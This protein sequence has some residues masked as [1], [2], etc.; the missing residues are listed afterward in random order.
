MAELNINAELRS[1][2]GKGAAR[3]ARSSGR[4]PAV[5]YGRGMDPLSISVDR[6]EYVTALHS[7]AGMNVLLNLQV[8]GESILALTKELQTDPVR[9]TVLHADFVKVDRTQEVEVDVPVHLVGEA[10]GV[11]EGG[12]LE[13]PLSQVHV[14]CLATQVPQHVDADI[15]GLTIGDTLRVSDLAEGREFH[16]LNDPAAVVV[17]VAAPISEEQLEAMVAEVAGP[18]EEAPEEEAAA[19]AAEAAEPTSEGGAPGEGER[20]PAEGETPPSEG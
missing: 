7:D 14:R 4:V 13:Q 18:A 2:S 20:M 17:S 19:E 1:E 15:S 3:R 16:I 6:R 9:G 12:I 11:K 8:N 10:P 5:V